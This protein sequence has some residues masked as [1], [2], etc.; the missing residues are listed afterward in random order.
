ME[1]L[2]FTKFVPGAR[3]VGDHCPRVPFTPAFIYSFKFTVWGCAEEKNCSSQPQKNNSCGCGPTVSP[4]SSDSPQCSGLGLVS[5][6]GLLTRSC[7]SGG[8]WCIVAQSIGARVRL[9]LGSNFR[10]VIFYPCDL[11]KLLSLIE[12][13]KE[14]PNY[15]TIALISHASKV[16]LKILQARL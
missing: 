2:S 4:G 8:Q 5:L 16:M 7:F 10:T 1:K 11:G 12:D 6:Q 13:A 15:H 3:K 14:C 9:G